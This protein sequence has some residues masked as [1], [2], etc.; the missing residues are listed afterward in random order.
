MNKVLK[1]WNCKAIHNSAVFKKKC[2]NR[3]NKRI[4]QK[5]IELLIAQYYLNKMSDIPIM[6]ITIL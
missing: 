5:D 4:E 3:S 6:N 1:K 2:D